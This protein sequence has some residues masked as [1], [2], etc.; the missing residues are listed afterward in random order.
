MSKTYYIYAHFTKDTN[1]LFYIGVGTGRR[2]WQKSTTQRSDYW[3][4]IV[5]KH[6]Y[7]V[8]II[9][10]GFTDRDEAVKEEIRLQKLNKP[11][12]CFEFGDGYAKYGRIHSKETKR[13]MSEAHKGKITSPETKE[14]LRVI[15]TGLKQSQ[16]T[17]D[18]RT[19]HFNKK[20]INCSGEIFASLKEAAKAYNLKSTSG[21]L[22]VC[23]REIKHAGRYEDN[24]QI[25]WSY[26]ND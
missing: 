23:K 5:N 10:D 12:A 26:I 4:R 22:G 14:K 3:H 20:V 17:I 9:L 2:A 25:S 24:S 19:K 6:G 18:K 11:R 7:E 8:Y 15:N 1:E 16:E 21:I 13:K